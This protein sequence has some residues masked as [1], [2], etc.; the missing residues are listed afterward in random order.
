MLK[1]VCKIIAV[2]L[3]GFIGGAIAPW[4]LGWLKN[5]TVQSPSNA[6]AIANTYIVFTTIIFVGITV[7]LAI[8]G[9]V[10][11][12]QFSASKESLEKQITEELQEKIQSDEG[13]GIK[14]ANS[15]LENP[16]V[17]RHLKIKLIS[18][19]EQLIQERIEDNQVTATKIDRTGAATK[20]LASQLKGK[21]N[22][23]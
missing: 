2:L 9:Y 10:F 19:V 15:I 17:K 13:C 20:Q 8:A 21:E 1:K 12:Q 3:A 18:K 6:I 23:D 22:D 5:A 11:M 4:F 7:V 14:L 16:D